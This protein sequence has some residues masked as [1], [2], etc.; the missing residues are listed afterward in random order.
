MKLAVKEDCARLGVT[1]T[2][3]R[4]GQTI[5]ALLSSWGV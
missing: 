3:E 4:N 5:D 1:A 2:G